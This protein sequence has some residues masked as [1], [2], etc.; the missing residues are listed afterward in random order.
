[1]IPLILVS[2]LAFLPFLVTRILPVSCMLSEISRLWAYRDSTPFFFLPF[3]LLAL[4]EMTTS[5][6]LVLSLLELS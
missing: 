2:P 6:A 3:S 5:P 1:M 4:S